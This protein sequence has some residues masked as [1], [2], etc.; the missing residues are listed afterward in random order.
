MKQAV[1]DRTRQNARCTRNR[2]AAV[3]KEA[4]Q[5]EHESVSTPVLAN[6]N[7]MHALTVQHYEVIQVYKTKVSVAKVDKIIFIPIK[8][9]DFFDDSLI[10]R[11]RNVLRIASPTNAIREAIRDIDILNLEPN[12][13]TIFSRLATDRIFQVIQPRPFLATG[14]AGLRTMTFDGE[15]GAN[16]TLANVLTASTASAAVAAASIKAALWNTN[17]QVGGLSNIFNIPVLRPQ[18]DS[19][20]L[21]VELKI[22]G[23]LIEAEGIALTPYFG[24][25]A[26]GV[27]ETIN[28]SSPL[29]LLDVSHISVKG[30][31]PDR[32]LTNGGYWT[33]TV[34]AGGVK[35]EVKKF[36]QANR[37][38]YSTAILRALDTMQ[39]ALLLSGYV[40]NIKEKVPSS[41]T[42]QP[43]E[44]KVRSVPVSQVVEPKPIR[45]VGNYLAFKMNTSN[46]DPDWADWLDL[47]SL[48]V[49][50]TTEDVVP[51]PS[52]GTF[53]EAVIGRYNCAE[54][55]DMA[56]FWNWQDSPILLLLSDIAAIHTGKHDTSDGTQG[57][58][59]L[60]SPIINMPAFGNMPVPTGTA[61]VLSAIQN[62]NMFRDQT[63]L[64]GTFELAQ[65][66]TQA[67][68]AAA[69]SA[70]QQNSVNVA[71][72]MQVNTERQGIQAQKEVAMAQNAGSNNS[73]GGLN[74]SQ[75]G[76]KVNYHDTIAKAAAQIANPGTAGSSFGGALTPGTSTGGGSS[77]GGPS[78]GGGRGALPQL[79]APSS[80][81]P[82]FNSAVWGDGAPRSA[83]LQRAVGGD[84]SS[85]SQVQR[86]AAFRGDPQDAAPWN[87]LI[88]FVVPA[89]IQRELAARDITVQKIEDAF[90]NQMNLDF[91]PIQI[92]KGP[93]AATQ[94]FFFFLR[95]H[96]DG[97]FIHESASK[98]YPFKV[99]IDKAR[100][101]SRN[102]LDAVMGIKIPIDNPAVVC[103]QKSDFLW[104][105]STVRT[106]FFGGNGCHPVSGTREWALRP[107]PGGGEDSW[108]SYTRG[109]DR[110]MEFFES[111][112]SYFTFEGGKKKLW[113]SLQASTKQWI[114]E[115]G[116]GEGVDA[117]VYI[118]ECSQKT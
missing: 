2:R 67:T 23:Y 6:Y 40:V 73:R 9:T 46:T 118:V 71:N 116:K 86:V 25:V 68:I 4:A 41:T 5:S 28:A 10:G 80:F 65:A 21:P 90:G 36:L 117:D 91:Y 105:F 92:D 50:Y 56:R 85:A 52:G 55:L 35:A 108:I 96:F 34:K 115:H 74:H 26:G 7:R 45:N 112:L 110:P 38:F 102:P 58:G 13:G 24:L 62:G 69:T 100:W 44:I 87:D 47:R 63:G 77:G 16:T 113:L 60:S 82:A 66:A 109:A 27:A 78:R 30:S 76:A 89:D 54:K 19:T 101:E 81:N 32:D 79:P 95:T 3:V 84:L 29:S 107:A 57:P 17:N 37:M 1:N 93:A 83:L 94:E 15:G 33:V 49:G 11:H 39:L 104:R 51:L 64:Q 106:A 48:K 98:F 114:N 59:Q 70:G 61:A 72:A 8:L 75:D 88:N 12:S 20:F 14:V 42:G 97:R 99:D 43:D 53:A 103:A 111:L 18:S 31:G 22:Q